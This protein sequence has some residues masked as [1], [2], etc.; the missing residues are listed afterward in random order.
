[1]R[2]GFWQREIILEIYKLRNFINVL[3]ENLLVAFGRKMMEHGI[4]AR[5]CQ[6]SRIPSQG[7]GLYFSG[8][9]LG[10]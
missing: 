3:E 6:Y 8:I 5:T 10:V 2:K 9:P 1:M 4:W 7:I